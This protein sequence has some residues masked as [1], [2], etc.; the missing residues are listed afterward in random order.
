MLFRFTLLTL[1]AG[2]CLAQDAGPKE[3]ALDLQTLSRYVGA[4]QMGSGDGPI[5]LVTLEN[6]QLFTRLG[7]QQA[8][9]IFPE[10]KTMFFPKVVKAEIEFTSDDE[11][12]R[13]TVLILHQNGRDMPAARL[14]DAKA[15]LIM[16][17]AAAFPKRLKD[18]TPAPGGE[19]ALRKMIVDLGSGKPDYSAVS[20]GLA[21]GPQLAQVQSMMSGLG[22]LQSLVFKGVGPGGADIYSAR[23]GKGALETRIWLGV[24]GKIENTNARPEEGAVGVP[25]A[26]LR[27]RLTEIDAMVAAELARRPVGSVTAGVVSGK[28]LIWSKSY[29]DANMEKKTAA[30]TGTVYRIG[31]ITKMFTALMLEQLVQAGKVHLS[32][33]VEKYFPEVK[34]V[35][36]RFPDAPPITLI[37]LATHTSGLGREPDDT[38]KYVTGAV[39]NWEKTLIA[40]LPHTHYTLEPGTRYSYSNIG[41]AILG[42][43][44]ARAA[45]EPYTEYVPKHI[46]QPLGMTHSALEWNAGMTPHLA[47][48]YQVMGPNGGVD[49]ETAQREHQ[50]GRGYKVP[51][52]A[53]YTTVGDMARFAAFLTGQGP[54]SVL[55]TGTL[56]SFQRQIVVPADFELTHG[57]GVGFEVERRG[58]YTEFGHG[59]AVA[60]YTASLL[61]NRKTGIGAIVLSSGAANPANVAQKALDILSK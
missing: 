26:N 58:N 47:K 20:P 25:V 12:G 30:D 41:F 28:D 13:P 10:S 14:E 59:G 31:S 4:Y 43:A 22:P 19:A 38:D 8:I 5:M 1:A 11:K 55:K 54:E 35:Q 29:G 61:M 48:G 57:Y 36:G 50:T 42:A 32:D 46:F 16:D 53:I 3:I 33:P 44:L 17:A 15:K 60:G 56:E 52:G 2:L 45:G 37:Q 6:N 9:P 18:Q 24:D 49:S 39:A 40:A 27:P 7:A 51:N 23:F 21:N 34:L